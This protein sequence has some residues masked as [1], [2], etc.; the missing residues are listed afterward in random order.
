MVR[1]DKKTGNLIIEI[2]PCFSPMEDLTFIRKALFHFVAN[3]DFDAI[4]GVD[5]FNVY[6]GL[7]DLIRHTEPTDKQWQ[8]ILQS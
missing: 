6:E 1:V 4:D 8:Q 5:R 7:I 3:S 2:K